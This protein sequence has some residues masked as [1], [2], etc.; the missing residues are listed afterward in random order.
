MLRK[1]IAFFLGILILSGCAEKSGEKDKPVRISP[2]EPRHFDVGDWALK[3]KL[4]QD[5]AD[6]FLKFGEAPGFNY[7]L[8]MAHEKI[9]ARSHERS[10]MLIYIHNG[11]GRFH[12]GEEDFF[13]SIGDIVYI[14]RGAVYSAASTGDMPLHFFSV[15]S[16][17]FNPDDVVYHDTGKEKGNN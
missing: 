1:L 15:Y 6:G 13:V 8:L 4:P 12:V 10:D 11:N 5:M 3:R 7:G 2:G 9:S 17:P 14:P 16:P